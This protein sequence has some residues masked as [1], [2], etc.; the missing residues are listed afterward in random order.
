MSIVLLVST[1][2]VAGAIG[3]AGSYFFVFRVAGEKAAT[4][5]ITHHG[6]HRE[7]VIM[8]QTRDRESK[9]G[10]VVPETVPKRQDVSTWLIIGCIV[11]SL[12]V[13]GIGV[14][15]YYSNREDARQRACFSGVVQQLTSVVGVRSSA[16]SLLEGAQSSLDRAK[17][18]K[19][20][21]LDRIIHLVYL[22]QQPDADP[23]K[24]R[25]EFVAA[26]TDAETAKRRVDQEEED[27]KKVERVV[28]DLRDSTP[29][30]TVNA[31]GPV[32]NGTE[33]PTP[34]P[35]P[36]N[37]SDQPNHHKKEGKK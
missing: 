20:H 33:D 21:T 36:V 24:L 6:E 15:A 18:A 17:S 26:L 34:T 23:V 9:P 12:L 13:A 32:D 11:F 5:H 37:P 10:S 22:G 19:E 14:Q 2:I 30:P 16:N 28:G 4:P 35:A 31:C 29:L 7:G 1:H 3:A 25:K 8:S 27:Y